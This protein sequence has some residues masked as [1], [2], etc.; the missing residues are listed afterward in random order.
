MLAVRKIEFPQALHIS[1]RCFATFAAAG[2][3]IPHLLSGC[4][5]A[6]IRKLPLR[7][8]RMYLDIEFTPER[9][10]CGFDLVNPGIVVE[11]KQPGRRIHDSS[12]DGGPT[13][14]E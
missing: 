5:P 3:W 10:E 6:T 8:F 14:R 7:L 2:T 11:T 12:A 9:F 13:R 4:F 1:Y